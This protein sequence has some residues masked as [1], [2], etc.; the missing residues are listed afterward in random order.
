LLLENNFNF[1][2][3]LNSMKWKKVSH[4]ESKEHRAWSKED[5]ENTLRLSSGQ[6]GKAGKEVITRWGKN[7]NTKRKDSPPASLE[8][9]STRSN[10]FRIA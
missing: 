2:V 7:E 9:Q 8:A 3:K 1:N 10:A 6:A 5:H 4:W